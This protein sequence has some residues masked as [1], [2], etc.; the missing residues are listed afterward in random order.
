MIKKL[1]IFLILCGCVGGPD[2]SHILVVDVTDGDTVVL[3]NG[4][5]LRYL[6]IDTPESRIKQ[7]NQ[8]VY[9]PQPFAK[10][11]TQLN[12]NLVL[13]K[14]VRIEFDVEK[15][16]KFNRLLG[17]CFVGDTFVN[18][19]LLEAGFAVLY[20][21]PPNVRYTTALIAAQKKARRQKS[22]LWAGHETIGPENALQYTNQI[23][24]IRGKVVSTKHS[25][26]FV[27][28][29]LGENTKKAF[30]I[31]LFKNA[32]DNFHAQG[33]DPLTFY[34][35]K[36]VEVSGRVRNYRG[37]PEIIVHAPSEIELL[38]T[39]ETGEHRRDNDE[40]PQ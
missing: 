2:Y 22:G 6:G 31:L 28:L 25:P 38:D 20:T 24:T 3:A 39:R 13:N 5:R 21:S 26:K 8:F 16:D 18:A 27:A 12:K 17:Y 29:R 35:G 40:M 1:L 34:T 19:R 23:R 15:H 7:G 4:E 36:I 11:A 32:I 14:V 33:I 37:R 10:E 30:S 9:A